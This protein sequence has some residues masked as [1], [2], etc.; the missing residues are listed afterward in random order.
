M[1]TRVVHDQRVCL[2]AL[3]AAGGD[4]EQEKHGAPYVRHPSGLQAVRAMVPA[5]CE[6]GAACGTCA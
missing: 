4:A 6:R 3:I 1:S 2:S 5:P